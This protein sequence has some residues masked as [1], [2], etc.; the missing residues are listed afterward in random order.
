[1]ERRIP[2]IKT[3]NQ[4]AKE[5][6]ISKNANLFYTRTSD[7]IGARINEAVEEERKVNDG[8]FT[9]HLAECGMYKFNGFNTTLDKE[10]VI[11]GSKDWMLNLK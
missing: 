7:D 3:P 6:F 11:N 8:S 10:R 9:K 5:N 4:I 2:L 1:M